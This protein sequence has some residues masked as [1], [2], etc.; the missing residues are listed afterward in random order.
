MIIWRPPAL[1]ILLLSLLIGGV[2]TMP[3]AWSIPEPGRSTVFPYMIQMIAAVIMV[4]WDLRYRKLNGR[5]VDD[6][7]VSVF[8]Y[9]IPTWVFAILIF[10][11]S[12]FM[13]ISKSTQVYSQARQLAT[14]TA[15][16]SKIITQ[17]VQNT[18]QYINKPTATP[19]TRPTSTPETV[20][21]DTTPVFSSGETLKPTALPVELRGIGVSAFSPDGSILALAG[22]KV[23]HIWDLK[24]SVLVTDLM[25][26]VD[27]IKDL[28]FNPQGTILASAGGRD[29]S[30]YLF[31]VQTLQ[32]TGILQTGFSET[33]R[34]SFSPDGTTLAA[35]SWSPTVQFWDMESK[36]MSA[37]FDNT[38]SLSVQA[39]QFNPDGHIWVAGDHDISLWDWQQAKLITKLPSLYSISS[40]MAISPNGRYIAAIDMAEVFLVFDTI[41][42]EKIADCPSCPNS[43][44][45]SFNYDSSLL[46]AGAFDGKV[47]VWETKTWTKV[48]FLEGHKTYPVSVVFAPNQNVLVTSDRIDVYLWDLNSLIH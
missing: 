23:I 43:A 16:I 47:H 22:D 26:S 20:Q 36:Q 10:I 40:K 41:S 4:V 45:M 21:L 44:R 29:G 7:S 33:L 24:N 30:I 28:A 15:I 27:F 32:Q 39:V 18:P 25:G 6:I 14:P 1:K 37:S 17:P 19:F 11:Y 2:I 38:G 8:F 34:I 9:I 12:G 31:D 42:S 5:A 48:A 46:A 3:I 35:C 13:F